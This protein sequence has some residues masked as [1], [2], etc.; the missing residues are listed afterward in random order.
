MLRTVE[1]TN[2]LSPAQ[3]VKLHRQDAG[4]QATCLARQLRLLGV[5]PK[6][7]V[8]P[9]GTSAGGI[10]LRVKVRKLITLQ[11]R[12]HGWLREIRGILES[13]VRL[14]L[15]LDDLGL[16]DKSI[17]CLQQFC[18]EVQAALREDGMPKQQ[19]GLCVAA[20]DI[21]L[22]AFQVISSAV[23]GCGP[24]YVAMNSEYMDA[25]ATSGDM[26]TDWSALFNRRAGPAPLWPVY[27]AGVRTRCPLLNN[28]ATN[29]LLPGAGIAVPA[30]T[31][32]LP[33]EL[34]VSR[35]ADASGILNREALAKAL[36]ACVVLGDRLFGL[37]S[38]PEQR[39]QS[40]AR[41]NRRLAVLLTGLGDLVLLRKANPADLACLR[42]LDQLVGYI[43][44][45]LWERSKQ[46]A[47]VCGPLP[48]LD[49]Q[50]PAGRWPD[51]SHNQDWK[52]RWQSAM[53]TAQVRHR[54]LLV[55]SPYSVL[56]RRGPVHEDYVD[57]LPLIAHADALSFASPPQC[58]DWNAGV[59]M[60]FHRRAWA[61]TQRRNA[62]SFIAAGV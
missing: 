50:H 19:L 5:E 58:P 25:A 55:M 9:W 10:A 42:E 15:S 7:R 33:M 13:G 17:D 35:F 30:G 20:S 44:N 3:P 29:A 21:A 26:A 41:L 57:L 34:D 4:E 36:N 48:A 31:A 45:T 59:F 6:I 43:H 1:T 49:Q 27:A 51:E 56:P 14:T 16:D 2:A 47:E 38:W 24:R 61:V 37:L 8:F 46:L 18:N 52:R 40:D 23:L 60:A 32:W 53:I 22:P 62:A 28:E 11:D 39:Q 54:N 12:L